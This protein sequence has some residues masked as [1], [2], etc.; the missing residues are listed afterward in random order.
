MITLQ[1]FIPSYKRE[2]QLAFLLNGAI[3]SAIHKKCTIHV[4]DD[5][6]C[7][8]SFLRELQSDGVIGVTYHSK[9]LGYAYT[10]FE[11]ILN[12][13]SDFL[14]IIND[15]DR[16]IGDSIDYILDNIARYDFVSTDYKNVEQ[17]L[18]RG[19]GS[20]RYYSRQR[21]YLQPTCSWFDIQARGS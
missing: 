11:G 16:I 10:L 17:Q 8:W 2:Q 5:G 19:G 1:F 4:T 15:D 18:I 7:G 12:S 6:V 14:A 13:T 3:N 21:S 20:L 9:N